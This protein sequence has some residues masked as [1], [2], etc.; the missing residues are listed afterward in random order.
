MSYN[1]GQRE[2]TGPAPTPCQYE[3]WWRERQRQADQQRGRSPVRSTIIPSDRPMAIFDPNVFRLIEP[4]QRTIDLEQ[5][6]Q[7]SHSESSP[8]NHITSVSL[9]SNFVLLE[10]ASTPRHQALP[11]KRYLRIVRRLWYSI[12]AVYQRLFTLIFIV[13][14]AAVLILL[15]CQSWDR[16]VAF[17]L[18]HL[19]TLASSNF[20]LAILFRQDWLI[21]LLFRTAWLVPWSLPLRIRRI[22]SRV[23]CYGGIHSGAA[24]MGTLWWIVFTAVISWEGV[25]RGNYTALILVLTLSISSLLATVIILSLPHF[26]VRHHDTWELTHRFLGWSS[27]LLFWI[28]I[29]LLT[30]YNATTTTTTPSS[31]FGARLIYTPTFYT[32]L[33]ITFLLMYPWLLL[34][35]WT[36]TATPLSPH[37]LRLSF[38]KKVHKYSCLVLSSSPLREWHPFAT[39]PNVGPNG[40]RNEGSLNGANSLV[41]SAAGDWTRN[42]IA[43]AQRE[44]REQKMLG[45][46]GEGVEMKFWVKSHPR[47]GVLS[48][49]CLYSRVLIVTTGSGIGPSL[50][51]LLDRPQGQVAR[52]CWSTRSPL[53][54]Y[55]EDMLKLVEKADPEALILNTDEMGRPDLLKVA[56]RLYVEMNAEAVFVLSNERVT[57]M[58]VGGL[59]R[60][61]VPAYG[62]IW[63]S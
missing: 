9:S 36:F 54:T 15:H 58:V 8:R 49:S 37:A 19:A 63:D 29:L 59:E 6:L 44:C 32:L 25:A 41:V 22:V 57:R 14:L 26:R 34:R 35:R 13:N 46:Q 21:N 24:V 1:Q 16:S 12:L 23:Y 30:H 42:L 11:P 3:H 52:L 2:A 17:K 28:Q 60:G 31:S 38:P 33:A 51:S 56:Y 27:I 45:K 50:S 43:T 62:P 20:L 7:Y 53:A 39:F 48:L 18:D 40:E 4:P 10:K 47:A 55:G 61:G 5:G